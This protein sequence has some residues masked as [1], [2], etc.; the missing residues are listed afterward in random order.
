MVVFGSVATAQLIVKEVCGRR[1]EQ[2]CGKLL[3][4]TSVSHL[5]PEEVIWA[6]YTRLT[7]TVLTTPLKSE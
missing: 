7:F 6:S 5:N 1:V 4:K 2:T 3:R